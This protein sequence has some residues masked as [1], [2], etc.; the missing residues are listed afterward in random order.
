MPRLPMREPEHIREDAARKLRKAQISGEFRAILGCLLDEV[1]TTPR[2]VEL[3]ISPEGKILA[4]LEGEE[5]F[6]TFLGKSV[7]DLLKYIRR[8]VKVAG[9]DGDEAGYLVAKVAEIK[10]LK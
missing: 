9:L 4:R 1:W 10:R 8:V 6:A 2:L 5:Y 7:E 3:L